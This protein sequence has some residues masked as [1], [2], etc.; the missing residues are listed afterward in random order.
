MPLVEQLV[1]QRCVQAGPLVLRLTP[2]KFPDVHSGYKPNCLTRVNHEG[3]PKVFPHR[4]GKMEYILSGCSFSSEKEQFNPILLL[5]RTIPSSLAKV[6]IAKELTFDPT[7]H[8]IS[9]YA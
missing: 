9:P 4:A 6:L 7:D 5:A 1:H 3:Q 8:R 2:R